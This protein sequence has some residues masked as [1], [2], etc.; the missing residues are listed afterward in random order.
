[1]P[2]KI[3]KSK[4]VITLSNNNISLCKNCFV[5]YFEKKTLKTIRKYKLI[6][7]RDHIVVAV[8]G[9]KDSISVLNILN[10]IASKKM[11]IKL[12]ALSVDEGIPN[13][14]NKTIQNAQK[15][16]KKHNIPHSVISF[17]KEFGKTIKEFK[18]DSPEMMAHG[19][20]GVLRR[21]VLNKYAKK[22][23]ATKLATGHNLDD[24]SQS[25][26]M[27]QLRHNIALSARL[28]PKTG[29]TK[30]SRFIPRIKPFYFLTEKET[31]LYAKLKD[32]LPKVT[33]GYPNRFNSNRFSIMNM[34]NNLE[35]K[36]PGSKHSLIASFM[37]IL[38]LLKEKYKGQKINSCKICKEPTSS[39]ICNACT[40]LKKIKE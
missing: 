29:V 20:C 14:R 28:G 21:H 40:L 30:D 34:L 15:Y 3:C 25:I 6:K 4:P 37:E 38:P 23:K 35:E 9:G 31:E 32:F 12:T 18:K 1:M 19:M 33:K 5:R 13:Y 11:D 17:K 36:Y 16:C 24:E 39:E 10:K 7:P 22:L 27:N 8:S 2:C 26:L